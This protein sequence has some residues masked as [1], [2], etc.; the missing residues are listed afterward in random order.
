MMENEQHSDAANHCLSLYG[1]PIVSKKQK[2][3]LQA[4][5]FKGSCGE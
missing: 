3:K 1:F 4:M 2:Y 5:C